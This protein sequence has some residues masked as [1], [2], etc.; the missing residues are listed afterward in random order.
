[1]FTILALGA[2]FVGVLYLLASALLV[3]T[4]AFD[5]LVWRRTSLPSGPV[6]VAA[7]HEM[8][9]LILT[10]GRW[11]AVAVLA[12]SLPR[13]VGVASLLDG[14]FPIRNRIEWLVFR[15]EWGFGLLA[16]LLAGLVSLIGYAWAT[17]H[18][19]GGWPLIWTGVL[20]I[21]IGTGL[22]GHP[23][24]SFS[25][26]TITPFLDGLHAVSTGAWLGAF[27]L[28]VIA[29]RRLPAHTASPWTDPM[30]AMLERYFRSSGALASLVLISGLLSAAMHLRATEDLQETDYGQLLAGKLGLVVI[31][32]ILNEHHRRHAERKARTAERAQLAH[33]LRFEAGL[34]GLI[35][36]L[37]AL[38]VDTDPPGHNEVRSEVFRAM[39]RGTAEL[40]S[41]EIKR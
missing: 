32:L 14:R 12:L 35:M 40:N 28:L 16:M 11:S 27:F 41:V 31:L 24:D 1:M 15:T 3:G 4:A 30:G 39:P 26:L 19:Q 6:R 36:A 38:L 18:R 22:Q 10:C 7:E 25:I 20:L 9:D 21:G 33:S 34:I 2:E 23:D 5:F 37:T 13:A 17:R 29:E 8:S